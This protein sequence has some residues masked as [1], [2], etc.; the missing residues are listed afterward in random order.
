MGAD[1]GPHRFCRAIA[2]TWPRP[3]SAY[4][5]VEAFTASSCRDSFS[6]SPDCWAAVA[7]HVVSGGDGDASAATV[8]EEQGLRACNVFSDNVNAVED[9]H[10]LWE[11]YAAFVWRYIQSVPRSHA[12]KSKS[13]LEWGKVCCSLDMKGG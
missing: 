2:S 6:S 10:R 12:T 7:Q 8:W 4:S 3:A 11:L 9:A 1:L 13:R 5:P